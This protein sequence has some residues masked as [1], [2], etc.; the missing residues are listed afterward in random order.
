ME[1]GSRAISA[2]QKITETLDLDQK[3]TTQQPHADNHPQHPRNVLETTHNTQ[4]NFTQFCFFRI[5]FFSCSVSF[6]STVQ[7]T[8]GVL[9]E[10]SGF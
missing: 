1:G 3:E 5:E 4:V 7:K 10:V 2:N 9:I 6:I 8:V